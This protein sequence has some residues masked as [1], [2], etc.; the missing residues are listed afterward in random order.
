MKAGDIV[1][2]NTPRGIGV[3]KIHTVA[4]SG[5]SG[6]HFAQVKTD[7]GIVNVYLKPDQKDKTWIEG[8]DREKLAA[9][10]AAEAMKA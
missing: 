8:E 2:A 10:L 5:N 7:V 6:P 4:P 9:C 3:G 1:T